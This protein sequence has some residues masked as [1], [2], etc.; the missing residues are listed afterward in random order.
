MAQITPNIIILG[1]QGSGKSTQA[2]ML[3]KTFGS[4]LIVTGQLVR[5][6]IK[7]NI[8]LSKKIKSY[9]ERGEL[10]PDDILFKKI[11]EPH[12]K[13]VNK[14]KAIIF[15]GIPRKP[16]QMNKLHLL[17]KKSKIKEPYLLYLYIP[18]SLVYKRILSRKICPKCEK[19]YK[20]KDI[21]YKKNLCPKCITKLVKRK[22]DTDKS[23]LRKRLSI[24]HKDTQKIINH[25][26][27]INRLIKID[28]RKSVTK[29]NKEVLKKIKKICNDNKK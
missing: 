17:I 29:V 10:V 25:Y 4:N 8:N 18:D 16:S 14:N 15:D 27:K 19:N 1:P 21:G 12:L 28:G 7:K 23:A 22:D 11:Y 26:K 20:P 9:V 24:F 13:R 5:N 2:E 3:A 6:T